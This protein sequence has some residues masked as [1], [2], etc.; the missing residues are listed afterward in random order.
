MSNHTA[1]SVALLEAFADAWKPHDA[2]ALMAFMTEDCVF[3][4]SAG[5]DVCGARYVGP[6][7]VRAAARDER[8]GERQSQ[9]LDTPRRHRARCLRP[10]RSRL[11]D[12]RAPVLS[13][14]AEQCLAVR[15][16]QGWVGAGPKPR[17]NE[18]PIGTLSVA[19]RDTATRS[20]S[21]ASRPSSCWRTIGAARRFRA[22]SGARA[23]S[24]AET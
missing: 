17:E 19:R 2:N 6:E 5:P 16:A 7:A 1:E 11:R 24:R 4:S 22:Q 8:A 15:D 18:R 3:E 14:V 13:R 10:T 9:R 12:V 23:P 21:S 20:S